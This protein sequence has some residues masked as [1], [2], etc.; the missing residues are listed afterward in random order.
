MFDDLL[1]RPVEEYRKSNTAYNTVRGVQKA[2]S[3]RIARNRREAKAS[4][5]KY[6]ELYRRPNIIQPKMDNWTWITDPDLHYRMNRKSYDSAFRWG[7]TSAVEGLFGMLGKPAGR[8]ASNAAGNMFDV[9]TNFDQGKPQNWSKV[10]ISS[11]K[12]LGKEGFIYGKARMKKSP[13]TWDHV[14]MQKELDT[15]YVTD[16]PTNDVY[17]DGARRQDDMLP[18]VSPG[19]RMPTPIRERI[20][21]GEDSDDEIYPDRQVIPDMETAD[22]SPEIRLPGTNMLVDM[23]Q[24][25]RSPYA[26]NFDTDGTGWTPKKTRGRHNWKLHGKSD[27]VL[28]NMLRGAGS[29]EI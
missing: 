7:L 28:R 11:A 2:K 15:W 22:R 17:W 1:S 18:Y 14:D 16:R 27:R 29:S 10:A 25:A 24:A 8:L 20:V 23:L 26:L 9:A 13:R 6:K 4:R 21:V 5:E 3:E 12:A 19:R